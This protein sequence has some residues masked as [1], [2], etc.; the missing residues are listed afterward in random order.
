MTTRRQSHYLST[1]TRTGTWFLHPPTRHLETLF[2]NHSH[3]KVLSMQTNS[4][5]PCRSRIAR[6]HS[7]PGHTESFR[8]STSGIKQLKQP[9][10]NWYDDNG[11]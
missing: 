2:V 1:E 6:P 8:C 7:D 3:R 9:S 11:L 4:S 5:R 10:S